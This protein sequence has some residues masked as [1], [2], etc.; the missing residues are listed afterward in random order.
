MKANVSKFIFTAFSD[1]IHVWIQIW[2]KFVSEGPTGKMLSF[3]A[4]RQ[5]GDKPLPKPMMTQT[6]GKHVL[7]GLTVLAHWGLVVHILMA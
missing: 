1:Y 3:V 6:A 4:W 5:T 7:L 2:L